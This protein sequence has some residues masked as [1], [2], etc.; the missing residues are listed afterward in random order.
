MSEEISIIDFKGIVV[1]PL[2][3]SPED[4]Y[5]LLE[6]ISEDIAYAISVMISQTFYLPDNFPLD[7]QL[8]MI[9]AYYNFPVITAPSGIMV[10]VKNQI[11]TQKSMIAIEESAKIE[12]VIIPAG[13][14]VNNKVIVKANDVPNAIASLIQLSTIKNPLSVKL[15]STYEMID[16]HHSIPPIPMFNIIFEDMGI[17]IAYISLRDD[18]INMI[19]ISMYLAYITNMQ[20]YD[21]LLDN[22]KTRESQAKVMRKLQLKTELDILTCNIYMT[23]AKEKFESKRWLQIVDHF[24]HSRTTLRNLESFFTKRE[25]EII[26]LTKKASDEH[27]ALLMNNKCMHIKLLEKHAYAEIEKIIDP[28]TE[29]DDWISCNICDQHLICQHTYKKYKLRGSPFKHILTELLKFALIDDDL[30]NATYYCKICGEKLVESFDLADTGTTRMVATEYDSTLKS[31][32]WSYTNRTVGVIRSKY[33]LDTK[34]MS[35]TITNAIYSSI[36]DNINKHRNITNEKTTAYIIVAVYAMIYKIITISNGVYTF[37]GKTAGPKLANEIVNYMYQHNNKYLALLNN[38]E[39]KQLFIDYFNNFIGFQVNTQDPL[40]IIEQLITQNPLYEYYSNGSHNV[41]KIFGMSIADITKSKN[42]YTNWKIKGNKLLE[43]V[44]EHIKIPYKEYRSDVTATLL[45]RSPHS[46]DIGIPARI[47]DIYGLDGH[48][49]IWNVY[50]YGKTSYTSKAEIDAVND[51]GTLSYRE[52]SI[53]HVNRDDTDKLDDNIIKTAL[54]DLNNI[55]MFYIYYQVRC[56]EGG[57]HTITDNTCVKCGF[58]VNMNKEELLS[59]YRKYKNSIHTESYVLPKH[60]QTHTIIKKLNFTHNIDIVSQLAKLID[61]PVNTLMGLGLT[62]GYKSEDIKNGL[63]FKNYKIN[64]EYDP[65]I[66]WLQSQILWVLST[67]EMLR[68]IKSIISVPIELKPF[69]N[70]D[71]NT[72]PSM[73]YEEYNIPTNELHS[74]YVIILCN[75]LLK[76]YDNAGSDV[77]H[78]LIN[79]ILRDAKLLTKIDK[80]DIIDEEIDDYQEINTIEEDREKNEDEGGGIDY[81]P[82]DED[83]GIGESDS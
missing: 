66:Y 26:K 72:L 33:F 45:F 65:A 53:C 3:M 50:V 32:I 82:E 62:A 22:Y 15:Q 40:D 80:T 74:S 75:I 83:S 4:A 73:E 10:R 30:T 35:N 31:S 57:I 63:H 60:E 79:R 76:I 6:N 61:I 7:V 27:V 47:S 77:V 9:L 19:D 23:I 8:R 14:F 13:T 59:Y 81:E 20:L 64:D 21:E 56:P 42:I 51:V 37:Q 18:Y 55:D 25:L 41:P 58:K 28:K 2:T 17:S 70:I 39:I 16:K 68:N 1:N 49:H 44:F 48:R 38:D 12:S 43:H 36:Y 46:D 5:Y 69:T 11:T 24:K 34:Y 52:C 78:M 29:K 71:T 67:Y 54:D